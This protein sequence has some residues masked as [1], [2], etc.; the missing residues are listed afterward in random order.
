MR[1]SIDRDNATGRAMLQLAIASAK[2]EPCS[3]REKTLVK[4]KRVGDTG[5][6]SIHRQ[7]T[8]GA[9][10]GHLREEGGIVEMRRFWVDGGLADYTQEEPRLLVMRQEAMVD[11]EGVDMAVGSTQGALVSADQ[12]EFP[13]VWT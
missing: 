3:A 8:L 11:E 5:D 2:M 10:V 4:L 7:G 13:S 1:E 6:G 12:H 9:A